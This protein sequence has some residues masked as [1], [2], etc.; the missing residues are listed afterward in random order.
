MKPSNLMAEIEGH[1]PSITLEDGRV[2]VKWW[3]HKIRGLH[4]NDLKL[5]EK[6][7]V[8]YRKSL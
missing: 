8:L 7:D 1:H 3:S 5:S 2:T 4:E 6:T